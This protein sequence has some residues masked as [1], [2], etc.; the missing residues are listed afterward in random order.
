MAKRRRRA[1]RG[2][3]SVIAVR[4]LS[5]LGK[6][7]RPGSTLGAVVPPLVGGGVAGAA[8]LLVEH[9]GK[10][11]AGQLASDTMVSLAENSEFV[12][13]GAG[14]LASAAIWGI[15][16]AP[17][18]VAALAAAAAVSGTVIAYRQLLKSESTAVTDPASGPTVGTNGLAGR[19]RM[20]LRGTGAIVAQRAIPGQ[21]GN[22]GAIVMEPSKLR[23]LGDPRGET[24]SLGAVNPGAFGTPGFNI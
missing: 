4:T 11:S 17:A 13:A 10:P 14:A 15:Y 6:V 19:Y 20:R 18:G 24:V 7:G 9:F 1:R 5:G 22:L 23:G 3:G 16:G 8:L 21:Y 2:T 12:S